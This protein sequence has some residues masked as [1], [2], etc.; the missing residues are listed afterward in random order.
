MPRRALLLA[1]PNKERRF[2]PWINH[3]GFRA[4]LSVMAQPLSAP[5]NQVLEPA[6]VVKETHARLGRI[7]REILEGTCTYAGVCLYLKNRQSQ[8]EATITLAN[9]DGR[10]V[11]EEVG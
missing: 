5:T 9:S 6:D 2:I 4:R 8:K 11:L 10:Y 3:G 7:A 1:S